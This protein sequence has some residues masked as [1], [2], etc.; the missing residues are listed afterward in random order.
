MLPSLGLG[1]LIVVLGVAV[2]LLPAVRGSTDLW[3]TQAIMELQRRRRFV[4]YEWLDSL[5]DGD[6]P[7]PSLLH[8]A[9]SRFPRKRW[10][11]VA[12][13][14]NLASDLVVALALFACLPLW[15]PYSLAP[16][17][18]TWLAFLIAACFVTTPVLVPIHAR[19]R[20]TNGR[21]PSLPLVAA[22]LLAAAFA[23]SATGLSASLAWTGIAAAGVLVTCLTSQFGA[24]ALIVIL[25]VTAAV[26]LSAWPLV[27]LVLAALV[28]WFVPAVGVRDLILFKVN[29]AL[30]YSSNRHRLAGVANRNLIPNALRAPLA[31]LRDPAR[32]RRLLLLE[33]PI[34]IA[35]YSL[36]LLFW[37]GAHALDP[38]I[39]AAWWGDPA[40]R[41]AL[42]CLAGATLAFLLTGT[43]PLTI[44]G[45][46]ERYFEYATPAMA[47]LAAT[48]AAA[49]PVGAERA[50]VVLVFL[51]V[52]II[53]L[54]QIFSDERNVRLL[55]KGTDSETP[56]K[57]LARFMASQQGELRTA[58]VPIKLAY[59]LSYF[60]V[61]ATDARVKF[62]YRFLMNRERRIDRFAGFDDETERQHLDLFAV[63]PRTLH[64]R[65]G[66]EW[67]ILWSEYERS[68]GHTDFIRALGAHPV[69][70]Q[71]D[72]YKVYRLRFDDSS[73]DPPAS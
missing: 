13:L 52:A 64:S 37:L 12:T 53:V 2:R 60:T 10:M 17:E 63:S 70:W 32:G 69:A 42:G 16:H 62:Y 33:S 26:S 39:R 47:L 50:L 5:I 41:F 1:L 58:T 48:V 61:R 4:T 6:M 49:S 59:L 9:V 72:S 29:H 30:W 51:N 73:P 65:Y 7:Y 3:G 22:T 27:A 20:A 19:L 46:A 25:P 24:Q 18:Q 36:P 11:L 45:Q 54:M 21:A 57:E 56:E 28:A 40:Q 43:G 71:N 14:V 35:A 31:L 44:F 15:L 38:G 66:I 67:I 8:F 55:T 34:W 23:S 68:Q